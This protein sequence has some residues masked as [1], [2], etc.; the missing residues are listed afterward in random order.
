MRRRSTP[1]RMVE[2][3]YA[4]VQDESLKACAALLIEASKLP[5]HQ[6]VAM[7]VSKIIY[8]AA[9]LA[10]VAGLIAAISGGGTPPSAS[11]ADNSPTVSPENLDVLKNAT[12]LAEN[13]EFPETT[14]QMIELAGYSCPR[15]TMLEIKEPSPYGTKLEALCGPR[16]S[17]GTY[18]HLHYAVYPE[19]FKISLCKPFEVF[20]PECN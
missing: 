5:D 10:I 2:E 17:T 20:G 16:G 3:A 7:D 18:R 13:P 9:G 19:K 4:Y 11:R 8:G 1:H 15:L 6:G 14:R 12:F